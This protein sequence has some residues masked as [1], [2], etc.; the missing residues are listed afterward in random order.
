[1]LAPRVNEFR[2]LRLG[3]QEIGWLFIALAFIALAIGLLWRWL[4]SRRCES[5][6][7]ISPQADAL[8]DEH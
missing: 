7:L 3:W 5:K 2:Q 6:E 8:F 1:M 4:L